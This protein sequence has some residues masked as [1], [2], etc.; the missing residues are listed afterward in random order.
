[1]RTFITKSFTLPCQTTTS[2]YFD[3]LVCIKSSIITLN[4]KLTPQFP[5]L[6][7]R[8]AFTVAVTNFLSSRK[9]VL[10]IKFHLVPNFIMTSFEGSALGLGIGP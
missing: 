5:S 4:L 8:H 6:P 2:D 3:K 7:L 9:L 10:I 1:M